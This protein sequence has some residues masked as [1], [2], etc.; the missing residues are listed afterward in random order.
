MTWEKMAL[1]TRI[2]LQPMSGG[3]SL[4][5]FPRGEADHSISVVGDSGQSADVSS[6]VRLLSPALK[7][8]NDTHFPLTLHFGSSF[9]TR[10]SVPSGSPTTVSALQV[11]NERMSIC[12][13]SGPRASSKEAVVGHHA[14][15][16][17]FR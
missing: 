7:Y 17:S 10:S 13:R 16:T 6:R 9:S 4:L 11:R 3:T 12:P 5:V 1:Y 2:A 8:G 14:S 15:L